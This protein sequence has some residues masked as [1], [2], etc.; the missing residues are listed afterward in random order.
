MIPFKSSESNPMKSQTS[1]KHSTIVCS[2][3][4]LLAALAWTPAHARVLDNFDDN[5]KTAWQDFTFIPGFGLPAEN[6]GQFRFALPPAGQAIFTASQKTSEVFELKEGRTVEFRVDVEEAG[7]KDSFPVLAFLPLTIGGNPN[8][9]GTLAGYGLA[10]STTD[11]LITKGIGRYFVADDGPTADLKNNLITLV[12]TMTVK[13][14]NVIITGKALD[15]ENNN[16]VM[17]ERTVVDTPAADVMADGDDSPKEP[18]ITTGY[19]TLYCYEDFSASAPEDPYFVYYDNAVVATPPAAANEP[20]IIS[21][22]LPA[23]FANFLPASTQISFKVADDKTLA[24][25]KISVTLNGTLFTTA[26]GLAVA[27][28]GSTKTATLGGLAANVNYTAMLSAEDSDG[29]SSSRTLYFDTFAED[30]LVLEIEDYNFTVEGVGGKFFD[31]PVPI[32]EGGGPQD[33]SY[34]NQIGTGNFEEAEPGNYVARPPVDF[35]DTRTTPDPQ[36]TLYRPNDPIRMQ[37]SLDAA[38]A[39]FT[40]A[41]GAAAGVYDYDVGDIAEGEWLNY[42]R[43]FPPGSYEAYLRQAVVNMTSGESVLEQVTGDPS[44]PSAASK[45][46]GSFLG[47]R[48][49]F[50]YRNFA[51]TDGTGQNKIIVRLSGVTTLRLRQVTPDAGDGGR[52]QT[53]LLLTPVQDPGLQRATI[54]SLSPA[55]GSAVET[56]TPSIRVEIQNR[57]TT[58]NTDTIKL[59]FNGQ[60]VVRNVTSDANGAVV[61]YS[62]PLAQL[63]AP[64]AN[65]TAK[66]SFKDNFNVEVSSEWN[67]VVNYLALDPANRQAGPGTERGFA[68][69]VVQ[70]PIEAGPL[71]ES[72]TRAEAQLAANST[73]PKFFDVTGVEQVINFAQDDR[74]NGLIPDDGPIP[75]LDD[76]AN[77]TDDFTMEL[78]GYLELPAGLYRFG[79]ITDNGYKIGSGKTPKDPSAM[80]LSFEDN[81]TA[82]E[83]FD[84][85]VREG[86]FYPFR[87]IWYERAGNAYAE[88]TSINLTTGERTL[89]NDPNTPTA[90]KAYLDVQTPVPTVKLESAEK[91]TGPYAVEGTA[92]INTDTKTITITRS[93]D[94][95]FY[96]LNAASTLRIKTW[97]LTATAIEL[98]Y[99]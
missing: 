73:I 38:R 8:S 88:L 33:G 37:H 59:Q 25:D 2:L 82:N 16:A 10:K 64:G 9:P 54:S 46:L 93:G 3:F 67:F 20:P 32:A 18:F 14:G 17:W 80:L 36:D 48:T 6:S 90:I 24:D 72:L 98:V 76:A 71:E 43:T 26:N 74:D 83:T 22:V 96:R 79:V 68:V 27:G 15:K 56:V 78:L 85:V 97:H 77:G 86:G 11:V 55:P 60:E 5:T 23:E 70:V 66:I 62:I 28:S 7:G 39:K 12:L 44:Q 65:N 69:R 57:D 1:F 13:D 89:I 40:A 41:G 94:T 21:E 4:V 19:F 95:R 31:N 42:T 34:S 63:P 35:N 30:S 29:V 52:Y 47:A 75:G 92:T 91:V 50:Q 61:T 81:G 53:Y 84:F 45:V 49:G 87:M 58:V 99:E 51:L